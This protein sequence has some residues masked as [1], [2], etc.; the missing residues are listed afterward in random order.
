MNYYLLLNGNQEGPFTFGQLRSMWDQGR[1]TAETMYWQEGMKEWEALGDISEC[2][3]SDWKARL[4]PK[5]ALIALL[6]VSLT[7]VALVILFRPR[8]APIPSPIVAQQTGKVKGEV[9]I[10]TKGGAN[11]KLGL[12]GISV[13]PLEPL[14]GLIADKV[15]FAQQERSELSLKVTS[16][17]AEAT[18]KNNAHKEAFKTILDPRHTQIDSQT[19]D[20][21]R[22]EW[23]AAEKVY[24]QLKEKYDYY[25]SGE[26]YLNDLP[27]PTAFEKTNSDG[28]FEL[29]LPIGNYA[30]AA[31]AKRSVGESEE[32]Y[33]WLIKT[34]VA[35]NQATKVLLSNDNMTTGK[36]QESLVFTAD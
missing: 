28:Q 8:S 1:I 34:S 2:G 22:R 19:D 31:T 30:I 33:H 16:A 17:E 9:F 25:L 13:F 18:R 4:N 32:V 11:Y 15:S 24:S 21:A 12:V 26:Y 27:A 14:R 3:D 7:I 23:L 35:P 20:Q 29:Q 10:V 36:A 6:V 5:H